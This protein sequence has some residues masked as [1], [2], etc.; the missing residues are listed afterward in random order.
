PRIAR[1]LQVAGVLRRP[2]ARPRALPR[3]ARRALSLRLRRGTRR[4]AARG[5]LDAARDGRRGDPPP[6]PD[7]RVAQCLVAIGW[8]PRGGAGVVVVVVVVAAGGF[9]F[10]GLFLA[11]P[12]C[13]I[14][15]CE[16]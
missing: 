9:F 5:R 8:A 14:V 10:A 7:A 2:A 4:H 12:M 1:A 15:G 3:G 16:T 13:T 11:G 6:H